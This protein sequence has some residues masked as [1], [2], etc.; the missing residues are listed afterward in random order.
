MNGFGQF[1]DVS[2]SVDFL[3]NLESHFVFLFSL[4]LLDHQCNAA[5]KLAWESIA[6]DV[7]GRLVDG[8]NALKLLKRSECAPPIEHIL[9]KAMQLQKVEL[10][11]IL[12]LKPDFAFEVVYMVMDVVKCR[13][14]ELRSP[15][16]CGFS[17]EPRWTA[18]DW[19]TW[20]EKRDADRANGVCF[21]KPGD[22][23]TSCD[24]ELLD[25]IPYR[26]RV[27]EYGSSGS[28]FGSHDVLQP[29]HIATLVEDLT[30]QMLRLLGSR[31]PNGNKVRFYECE[32]Y[33]FKSNAPRKCVRRGNYLRWV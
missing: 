21:R 3:L 25:T 12:R 11:R 23:R 8:M 5:A 27:Y 7:R 26:E 18:V 15:Q 30:P 20:Q 4:A 33:P 22:G 28:L 24:L 10:S 31:I 17:D 29:V 2:T 32:T 16:P 1:L 9:T 14:C 13:W 19:R 6:F